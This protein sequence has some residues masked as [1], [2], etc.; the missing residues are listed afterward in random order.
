MIYPKIRDNEFF[1]MS[2]SKMFV[3]N[4]DFEVY[5]MLCFTSKLNAKSVCGGS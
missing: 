3:S 1:K 2:A 5:D 4:K